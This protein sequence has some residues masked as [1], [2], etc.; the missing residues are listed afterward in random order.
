MTIHPFASSRIEVLLEL[1]LAHEVNDNVDTFSISGSLDFGF[2]VTFMVI[3]YLVGTM[4]FAEV[5]LGLRSNGG[6]YGRCA[7]CF[8]KLYSGNGDR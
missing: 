2:P 1:L 4:A 5:Y 8:A 3:A 6:I 7:K